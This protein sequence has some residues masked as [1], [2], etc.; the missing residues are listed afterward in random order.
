MNDRA[1]RAQEEWQR[2]RPD[3][4]AN[5]MALVGRLLQATHLLERNWFLPLAAQFEL[6]QGEF[7][8]IATLRRSG[9]PYAMTP[10]DLH[11]G[12]MLSSGAMTSRLDRLE[13]KGLIERVP[14]PNDRRSTLVRLTPAGLALIDKL[15]PLHVANEQQALA[16]LTQK[17]QAQ[18]DGLLAK[19]LV[20]LGRKP[21]D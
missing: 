9:S 17:E 10:T 4:D 18:L 21:G 12:L 6:H 11:E 2:E 8:V 16:S 15:L 5:V 19:L 13:R 20:G 7:D 1:R 3:I 14:S